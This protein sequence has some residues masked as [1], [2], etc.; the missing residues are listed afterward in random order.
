MEKI[1]IPLE[2]FVVDR[3]SKFTFR[4]NYVEFLLMEA[5]VDGKQVL[6]ETPNAKPYCKGYIH[7][8]NKIGA[9]NN[10]GL[11]GHSISFLYD[12]ETVYVKKDVRMEL[13]KA[14]Y[15]LNRAQISRLLEV[16]GELFELSLEDHEKA[17]I[18]ECFSRFTT[19]GYIHTDIINN[20]KNGRKIQAIKAYRVAHGVGLKDS[21]EAIDKIWDDVRS[22]LY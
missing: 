13:F 4:I 20:I 7:T 9:E 1:E 12:G 16:D 19:D 5:F 8:S 17:L 6:L 14:V 22:G 10:L 21:K 15:N 18:H 11:D 2:P 3:H